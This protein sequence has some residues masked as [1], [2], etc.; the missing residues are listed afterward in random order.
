[1]G[2]FQDLLG[3][4]QRKDLKQAKAQADTALQTG[5]QQGNAYYDA[6]TGT[7]QP[8][9]QGGTQANDLYLN[10]IGVNG[11]DAQQQV[12]DNFL[13][14]P[15]R[16]QNGQL[17][18]EALVRSLNARGASRGGLAAL[19]VSRANLERGSEDYNNWLNRLQGASTQGASA[20]GAQAGV[21]T[22]QGDLNFGAGQQKAANAINYGNAMA[23][24][25]SIGINNILGIA[26]LG[27]AGFTPTK[28]GATAFGNIGN[29]LKS[30]YNYLTG[31]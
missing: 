2:F 31:N 30:G 10:A 9:V 7:L 23:Q 14:D 20:A 5:T 4:S 12:Q 17:A 29:A 21:Q 1:M 27:I 26:G 15:F 28:T 11:Q 25:R 13:T 16:A 6:A 3:S 18:D 19:A 8:F 22:G 24:S